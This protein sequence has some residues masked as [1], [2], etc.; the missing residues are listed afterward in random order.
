MAALLIQM[1]H[2]G[3]Q[4]H[5]LS[6]GQGFSGDLL[7][8]CHGLHVVMIDIAP[9]SDADFTKMDAE[10]RDFIVIDHHVSNHA[11][12]AGKENY[13]PVNVLSGASAAYL[14]VD[15]PN[16]FGPNQ[17]LVFDAVRYIQERDTWSWNKDTEEES[18]KWSLSLN[19]IIVPLGNEEA[20]RVLCGVISSESEFR[21]IESDPTGAWK[22]LRDGVAEIARIAVLVNL[23][24]QKS[25][26]LVD[27]RDRTDLSIAI[28]D[29]GNELS[30]ERGSPVLFARNSRSD[31]GAVTFSLRGEN[32]IDIAKLFG[33]GGHRNAA[34][35]T[36]SAE[37]AT[38]A[39][40]L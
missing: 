40:G 25:V 37:E 12:F 36:L 39:F 29:G 1:C 3:C 11:K 35:F 7:K 4:I 5:F 9:A 24:G 30:S 31:P 17:R 10:T 8:A 26:L 18:K 19:A 21:R 2:P 34:G 22:Q 6:P 32:C 13:F 28:N 20:L 23:P 33:G 27:L 38:K 14:Y 16:V 15:G